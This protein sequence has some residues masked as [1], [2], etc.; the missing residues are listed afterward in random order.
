MVRCYSIRH[1]HRSPCSYSWVNYSSRRTE[2][3][4]EYFVIDL[5]F[6]KADAPWC[7]NKRC[8]DSNSWHIDPKASVLPTT[9]QCPTLNLLTH[10]RYYFLIASPHMQIFFV[11]VISFCEEIV[12]VIVIVTFNVNSAIVL[13]P[14][15]L[16]AALGGLRPSLSN[17]PPHLQILATPLPIHPNWSRATP[18]RTTFTKIGQSSELQTVY[19]ANNGNLSW[20]SRYWITDTVLIQWRRHIFHGWECMGGNE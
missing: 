11:T 14:R 17:R 15:L 3:S 8:L 5:S 6:L 7:E 19:I 10:L 1:T 9:P 2:S 18:Q 13:S 16:P 4:S 12:I 20:N